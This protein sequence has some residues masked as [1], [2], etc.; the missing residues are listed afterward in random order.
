M[1]LLKK[2]K[3]YK[4]LASIIKDVDKETRSQLIDGYKNRKQFYEVEGVTADLKGLIKCA[5]CP[6]MC[7]FDCPPLQAMKK[8]TYSPAN[9]AKIG[10]WMGMERI[11]LD[12]LS[13]QNA[14][15]MCCN[16][17]ACNIWCPM[18]LSTGDLLETMRWELE[19][20][21]LLPEN[22][23][24]RA[25]M[26]KTNGSIFETNIFKE[27]AEEFD[28]NE[29]KPDIFYFIG[30]NAL[31][32]RSESVKAHLELFKRLGFKVETKLTERLC[33]TSPLLHLGAKELA[34]EMSEKNAELLN[35]S[36]AKYIISECPGC[37]DMLKNGIEIFDLKIKK[38]ILHSSEFFLQQIKDG[39]LKLSKSVDKKIGFHDPCILARDHSRETNPLHELL[40]LIPGLT[41]NKVLMEKK[42]TRCCG[43]GGGFGLNKP[44]IA[45]QLRK[46][47]YEQ[48]CKDEPDILVSACPTCEF[49]LTE[50]GP[51]ETVNIAQLLLDASD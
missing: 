33:C 17:D 15:Y 19:K 36:K 12:N 11:P 1:D 2:L 34:R 23:Q 29:E 24:N 6:N 45:E 25:N 51:K 46:D 50:A 39:K 35:D 3:K 14:L 37:S 28:T 47:R 9:K 4:W 7:R 16:C 38:D 42:E 48:L 44:E 8:E 20:H 31:K 13:A 49:A 41:K 5:N 26:V 43:Y 27:N 10:Y 18:D 22:V 40:D 21:D 30:C 32:T